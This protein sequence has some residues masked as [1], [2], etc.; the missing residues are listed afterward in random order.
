[1]ADGAAPLLPSNSGDRTGIS[2]E[3]SEP[4]FNKK[5]TP[6]NF[7]NDAIE[8]Y[9]DAAAGPTHLL[10]P[11]LAAFAWFFDAQQAFISIFSDASPPWH[12][13][14]SACTTSIT[15]CNFPYSSWSYS[16]PRHVSTMS[17][18]SLYCASPV[19]LGLPASAFFGGCLFGGLLLATIADSQLGRKK[20]L[21]LTTLFMSIASA[22]TAFS[23]NVAVYA[24]LRFV[25]GFARANIGTC[26][27]ILSSELVP[28]RRRDLISILNFFFYTIDRLPLPTRHCFQSPRWLLVKGRAEEA[29]ETLKNLTFC[30]KQSFSDLKEIEITGAAENNIFSAASILCGKRWAVRRLAAI[31][32]VSFGVG[33]VYYG[34]PLNLGNLSADLYL[35]TALNAVAELPSS[36]AAFL[37]ARWMKRRS[38][39][40]AFTTVSGIC[41][42]ICTL[43]AG[44][45][46]S[47]M[48]VELASF[49]AA[50][51]ACNVLIIY[52]VEL[53]PTCV[54]NSAIAVVRL[55]IVLGGAVAPVMVAMG[56][57]RRFLSFGVFGAVI[58]FAGLFAGFLPETKGCGISDTME[59]E[60]IKEIAARNAGP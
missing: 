11:T 15:P 16:L 53:F 22:L 44:G 52:S 39:M 7:I 43:M 25:S 42:I 49:F 60:E 33:M 55:V 45:G 30:E 28:R 54:R 27:F 9:M 46:W 18:F 57:Q 20:T 14:T 41:S 17:D 24:T 58:L 21:V 34:M 35:S 40:V 5:K 37:I 59:E 31:T 23:P 12:C 50:C 10:L 56:R 29:I 19:L 32:A 47:E 13:T 4:S 1:M 3:S 36:L 2:Q 48:A 6:A 8:R 26:A 51:T 38:S